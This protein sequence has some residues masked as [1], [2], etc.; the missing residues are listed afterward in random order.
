MRSTQS[1]VTT[2]VK[3]GARGS[4][5]SLTGPLSAILRELECVV[6]SATSQQFVRGCGEQFFGATIGGHIR[7]CLD[8]VRAMVDGQARGEIDYD[9]RE[10]GTDIESNVASA[11]A[12]I[13]RLAGRLDGLGGADLNERVRVRV[14]PTRNGG[15]VAVESTIGR[16][17]SF[18]LSHTI[19]HNAMVRSMAFAVEV[20]VPE[21][22]GYA[23][24][25]LAHR[26]AD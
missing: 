7:H 4:A 23:P 9:L 25:T 11:G 13:A 15:S 2:E 3:A 8:H 10:R 18:V 21:S 1:A 19:H 12:E 20:R 6:A 22:F 24:S 5:A 14:M 26:D 17:L 16:E